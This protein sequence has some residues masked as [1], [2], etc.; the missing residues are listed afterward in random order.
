M[1]EMY[2]FWGAGENISPEY[3][4]F[5]EDLF[6]VDREGEKTLAVQ[7]IPG[8]KQA[9]IC[10]C[11]Q[12]EKVNGKAK[13]SYVVSVLN[14]MAKG[15]FCSL[16]IGLIISQLGKL[17]GIDFL[18]TTAAVIKCMMGP[19]IGVGVAAS[20]GAKPYGIMSAAVSAAVGAG[21]V[22]AAGSVAIG[23]PVGALVGGLLA[24]EISKCI[25]QKTGFDLLLVPFFSI[26]VSGFISLQIAP[27]LSAAMSYT[28][29]FINELTT[30]HPIPMGLLIAVIMGILL[31]LP[32]S[33]AALAITLG[34]SGIA[35]GASTVGC[36]CQMIGFAVISYKENR[37]PGL[38]SLGLG[39]SMLQIGNIVKNPWIIV[40]PLCASAVLGPISTYVLHLENN[41]VGAGMGTSG[42]VGQ[43]A[44]VETM[45]VSSLP[46]VIIMHIVLPAVLSLA[47]YRVLVKWKRIKG[48]DLKI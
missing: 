16:I 23:D 44:A 1:P 13:V 11:L 2:S 24:A 30:I 3:G 5:R 19:A 26:L 14:G 45:G 39:T 8:R 22:P 48:G 15:L 25:E 42:L 18:I 47:A 34:L 4:A 17:S 40:P 29:A 41:P 33:S 12:G 20:V 9:I 10:S 31:T 6:A 21:T 27:F 7:N 37:I 46:L 28:G 36:S 32:V 38:I 43:F 35:A